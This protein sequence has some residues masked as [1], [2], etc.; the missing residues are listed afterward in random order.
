MKKYFVTSDIHS[1]YTPLKKALDDAG[2]DIKNP[3]HCL[4]VCGDIF[5]RGHE[6][7]QVY[8][9]L[10][11]IPKSRRLM[12]K[13][14]HEEL[15][16]AL[17]KKSFPDHHDFSNGTVRTFC[18]IA[19]VPEESLD[20]AFY[21]DE[22]SVLDTWKQIVSKVRKHPITKWLKSDEWHNFYE[23]GKYIFVHSFIPVKFKKEYEYI[24]LYYPQ[25][26]VNPAKCLD[27]D[28][29]WR[30]TDN[31]SEA[32]WGCPWRQYKAGL[33]KPEE[34]QGKTLVCGHWHA[35]EFRVGLDGVRYQSK[36]EVD[37]STYVSPGIIGLDA[38]TVVSGISNVYVIEEE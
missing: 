1:F 33:F 12:V 4:I 6:T 21:A 14:N 35:W 27:F 25:S 2:F 31:W 37:F 30:Y 18:A 17:L 32:L 9:F 13:G 29:E 34:D 16:M 20:Y 24:S 10:R 19:D 22:T 5:D 15:Y 23:I 38:C 26:E 11:S 28:S 8:K 36:E 7:M 3:E